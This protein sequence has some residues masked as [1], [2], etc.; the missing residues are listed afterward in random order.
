VQIDKRFSRAV[1][2]PVRLDLVRHSP[3]GFEWG[4]AGSGPAQL[5]CAILANVLGNGLEE[6]AVKWH[7]AFKREVIVK[8]PQDKW[9][10]TSTQILDILNKLEGPGKGGDRG[11]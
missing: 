1:A 8:L 7:Q 4:Y 5:A 9:E 11:G 10:L 6:R 2:L 3:T